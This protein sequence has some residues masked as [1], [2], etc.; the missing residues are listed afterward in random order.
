M[1][2]SI[3]PPSLSVPESVAPESITPPSASAPE[4][5]TPPSSDVPDSNPA[6]FRPTAESRAPRLPE[7]A[8]AE[9][10]SAATKMM[11]PRM[12]NLSIPDLDA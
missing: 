9:T 12:A 3:A 7:P 1:P 4:S 8:Q 6:S 2:E 5:I 11:I 10:L